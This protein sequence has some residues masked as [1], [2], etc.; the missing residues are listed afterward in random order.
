MPR[1]VSLL[2]VTPAART[3]RTKSCVFIV[4]EALKPRRRSR[5]CADLY[6]K[7]THFQTDFQAHLQAHFTFTLVETYQCE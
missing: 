7:V 6:V 5:S 3:A 4:T 1:A 2:N